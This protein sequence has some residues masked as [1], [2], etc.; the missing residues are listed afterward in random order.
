M[1]LVKDIEDETPTAEFDAPLPPHAALERARG[2]FPC[3][4]EADTVPIPP[5]TAGPLTTEAFSAVLPVPGRETTLRGG[6]SADEATREF[7]S[8]LPLPARV[9]RR[10]PPRP[11]EPGQA[12]GDFVLERPL[13]ADEAWEVFAARHP[14]YG[15][16]RLSVATPRA[17]AHLQSA[18]LDARL[19][20]ALE[21]PA[22]PRVLGL[23]ALPRPWIA[24]PLCEGRSLADRLRRGPPLAREDLAEWVARAALALDHAHQRRV[25]HGDLRPEDLLEGSIVVTG[26]GRGAV[27]DG[28]G[29]RLLFPSGPSAGDARYAPPERCR[30]GRQTPR[31]DIYALGAL[32]Y[33]GVTGRAPFR[34]RPP[35]VLRGVLDRQAVRPALP[36]D[37]LEGRLLAVALRALSK[38]PSQRHA[39]AALFAEEIRAAVRGARDGEEPQR[40][41]AHWP[42]LLLLCLATAATAAAGVWLSLP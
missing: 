2:P 35:E 4:P 41:R 37:G 23:G 36:A 34:G 32:L 17:T 38:N 21:H 26:F 5:P 27:F 12:V 39:T 33:E 29:R 11:L 8:L 7:G 15:A 18:L 6:A 22:L 20:T 40:A 9:P 10:R 28:E 25:V 13:S 1:R 42:V 30:G 16:C 31:G 24:E 3:D 14:R 19:R